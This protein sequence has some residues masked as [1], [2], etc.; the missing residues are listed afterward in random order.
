[1]STTIKTTPAQAG[2][3]RRICPDFVQI[4]DL[5]RY[6]SIAV[7]NISALFG[8]IVC[9]KNRIEKSPLHGA[10]DA[11]WRASKART[12]IALEKKLRAI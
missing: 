10:R 12:L 3:A 5:D 9:E 7:T 4:N 1:M 8:A 11:L 2:M 6:D